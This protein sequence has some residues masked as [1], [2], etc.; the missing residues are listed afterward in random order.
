ANAAIWAEARFGAARGAHDVIGV[1][2]GTG[3]GGAVIIGDHLQRGA[4]GFGGEF[5]HLRVE[6]DGHPCPCGQRGCL[7]QYASGSALT[8]FARELVA[9]RGSQA[10][11]LY[12]LAEGDPDRVTGP[13]VTEAARAGDEQAKGVFTQ[14]ATWLGRGL[15]TLSSALDPGVIVVGGGL[16][17]ASDLF[18]DTVRE[19]YAATLTA[20]DYRNVAKILPAELGQ[21]A[22]FLGAA[23]LA[24][25]G[26]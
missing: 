19:V 5:G 3:V 11:M 21:D 23:D 17:D 18:L 24:A 12:A 13:M 25:T 26:G 15:S 6:P 9:E 22:G 1:T 20:A 2:I 10:G 7:E 4:N 8:R 16:V 14:L